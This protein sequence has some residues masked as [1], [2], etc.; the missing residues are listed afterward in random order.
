MGVLQWLLVHHPTQLAGA[1]QSFALR[2][3]TRPRSE[4]KRGEA[5]FFASVMIAR[6]LGES[7]ENSAT[8]GKTLFL[9]ER[10]GFFART[11][12]IGVSTTTAKKG[13]ALLYRIKC[14]CRF[15]A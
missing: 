14:G 12:L 2:K 10:R 3:G 13:C 4:A 9:S 7:A 11:S 8:N 15:V 6:C 5:F 1:V